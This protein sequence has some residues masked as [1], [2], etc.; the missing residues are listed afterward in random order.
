MNFGILGS[1]AI[2]GA[3]AARFA[4]KNID[5]GVA[6]SRGPDSLADLVNRLGPC[7]HPLT[8]PELLALDVV[9]LAVPF[10]GIRAAVAGA[11]DWNGR[12]V[13][14]ASNAIDF[15]DFTPTDLGGRPSTE[16]VAELVPGA[17]VAKAFNTLPAATLA[18]EPRQGDRRRVLFLSGNDAAG[19]AKLRDLIAMLG[20]SPI[21]VGRL[22]QGG[23]LMQF[24]G[25]LTNHDLLDH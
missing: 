3:L 24:G 5:V 18:A 4:S 14:D 19:N 17:T 11:A 2:G 8:V 10:T 7:I 16:L 12:L 20:F 23:R 1:G 25:P 6:N 15:P 21:D 9:I 22:D 13:V